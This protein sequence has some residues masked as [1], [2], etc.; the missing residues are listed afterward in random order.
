MCNCLELESHDDEEKRSVLTEIRTM[1]TLGTSLQN[2]FVNI[3]VGHGDI[4]EV[5]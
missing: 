2:V 3:Q 5:D 4:Y 1:D